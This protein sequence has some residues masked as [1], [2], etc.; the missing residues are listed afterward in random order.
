MDVTERGLGAKRSASAR[1]LPT[2]LTVTEAAEQL[3]V[4]TS[5]IYEAIRTRKLPAWRFGTRWL[6][7]LDGIAAALTAT[8]AEEETN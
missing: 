1:A 2:Y 8:V 3:R 4:S 7:S 5:T 6:L